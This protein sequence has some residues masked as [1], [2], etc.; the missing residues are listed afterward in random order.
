M[1]ET[2]TIT[3]ATVVKKASFMTDRHTA[4]LLKDI[5]AH[6]SVKYRF[7]FAVFED[8]ATQPCLMVTSEVIAITTS[9]K[10]GS[11]LLCLFTGGIGEE[12]GASN[13]WSDIEKFE[14][15]AVDLAAGHLKR[16]KEHVSTEVLEY[17]DR[18]GA[19][20]SRSP[21]SRIWR[22]DPSD[23]ETEWKRLS[24]DNACVFDFPATSSLVRY[25]CG[26]SEL[27]F[28]DSSRKDQL[29]SAVNQRFIGFRITAHMHR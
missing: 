18:V 8:Q 4:V 28:F 10:S 7:I 25:L 2:P 16:G 5:E 6:G 19:P 24:R 1:K 11:H 3:N 23:W 15:A 27:G 17:L 20:A 12:L 29:K 13:D 26:T 21:S 9:P 14:K 22:Q